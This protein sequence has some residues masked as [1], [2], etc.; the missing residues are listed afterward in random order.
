MKHLT[1]EQIVLHC[2]GDA[3]SGENIERHLA[4]CSE[5][6][7]EFENVK[8]LLKEIPASAVPE[9]PA[10][11]EQKLW[12]NLR[13]HLIEE[14][15]P[16]WRRFFAPQKLATAAA[17]IVLVLAAFVAGRFWP[18]PG[19]PGNQPPE[20]AQANPGRV[21]LLAVGDH[22][23]RSQ[24]LL[25]EIMN[26]DAKDKTAITG[27][28]E[29]ARNLLDDNRLYRQSA[30]RNGDPEVARLLDEL[31]R[32]LVE[33]ANAPPDASAANLHEIRGRIQSQDLLFKIH[34]LGTKISRPESRYDSGSGTQ[35]L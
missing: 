15:S 12:L 30:Q 32:V 1:E 8:A 33:V 24:M 31:E 18:R 13:D 16:M 3:E 6:R 22:L 2:Y 4:V 27:E 7:G 21:V 28:Q 17:V 19:N 11:L 35:R 5:C 14:K 34:A 23:E 9:P 26:S 25:I 10:Y 20:V 29:L